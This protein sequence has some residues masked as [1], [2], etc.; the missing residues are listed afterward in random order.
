MEYYEQLYNTKFNKLDKI[1]NLDKLLGRQTTK[2][3][4]EEKNNLNWPV[5]IKKFEYIL[6]NLP[7]KK[8]QPQMVS[9]VDPMKILRKK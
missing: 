4:Q 7:T 9:L 1:D 5:L 6:K 2:L 3:I 8:V